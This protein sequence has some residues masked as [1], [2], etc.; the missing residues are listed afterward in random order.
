MIVI[1]QDHL[2]FLWEYLVTD[3]LIDNY[4]VLPYE[5]TLFTLEGKLLT[6]GYTILLAIGTS[7]SILL[8]FLFT[9]LAMSIL[10]YFDLHEI[11]GHL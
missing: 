3:L 4:H 9:V 7:L 8:I 5:S 6:N 2:Y 11:L 1:P 10:F